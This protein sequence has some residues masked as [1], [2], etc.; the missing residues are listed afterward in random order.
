[1]RR[2][3][4]LGGFRSDAVQ[5]LKPFASEQKTNQLFDSM[6]AYLLDLAVKKGIPKGVQLAKPYLFGAGA[7]VGGTFLMSA[8]ALVLAIRSARR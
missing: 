5:F 7:V 2:V 8:A 4:L 1:M 3:I 6:E